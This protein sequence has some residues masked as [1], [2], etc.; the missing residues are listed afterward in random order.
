MNEL[1]YHTITP[2]AQEVGGDYM[3]ILTANSTIEE[4]VQYILSSKVI[5]FY[6]GM[7]YH[8]VFAFEDVENAMIVYYYTAEGTVTSYRVGDSA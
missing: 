8:Q 2:T 1:I 5:W 7:L 4:I 6:D 3:L